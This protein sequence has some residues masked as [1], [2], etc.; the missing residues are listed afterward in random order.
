MR[1]YDPEL[2]GAGRCQNPILMTDLSDPDVIRVEEDYYLVSSSFTYLPGVPLLHSRDLIHWRQLS[3]CVQSLPFSR[4]DRPCHGCGT[5]APAIRYHEGAFYVFVPLPDE[6]IFVTTAR[7]PAGPWTPLHPIWEGKGWIDPCPFWDEDGR[8]YMVHAYAN[9]RC[10]IKHRIDI[11]SMA[12]DASSLLDEGHMVYQNQLLHPTMEGPKMYKRSGWYYI[13]APAGGVGT[14]WQTVLRSR[15]PLGPYEARIVLHQGNTPVNGPHQG[16]WVDTP[17][18]ADWFF[19]FQDRGIY[20]RVLHLQPMCWVDDW[21]FI[22]QESNGDGVGEP[23]ESW[24]LPLPARPEGFDLAHDDLFTG[25]ELGFPWQWQANP[26]RAWY[27]TGHGLELKILPCGRGESLLWYMPNL[28]TQ[29][30]QAPA[31]TME[32]ALTLRPQSEGEEAGI[33]VMGHSYSALA[34]HHGQAGGELRLYRGSV[35]AQTPEGEAR[36]EMVFST[37]C[38]QESVTLRLHFMPGGRVSYGILSP[39]GEEQSLPGVFQADKPTWSGAR[40][41]LFARSTRNAPGGAGLFH[42]VSF[43]PPEP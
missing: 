19:H 25:P 5:W 9:S 6:G 20:G 24:P 31:F 38:P 22:G 21:P 14:G 18:G 40:P 30:A 2:P 15:H 41:A 10:G 26:Q 12:P 35:T 28:L 4:Y 1:L 23:V 34:L 7:D 17:E 27:E 29:M 33:A 43:F 16:A 3:W 13:F 39:Q 37:P 8:A 32:A 36:E 42:S 11:C